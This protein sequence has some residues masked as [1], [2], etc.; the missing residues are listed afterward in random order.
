MKKGKKDSYEKYVKLDN[1][2]T[3]SAA[4]TSL[5]FGATW[6]YIEMRKTFDY[7]KGGNDHL[8]L[9][10]SSVR[11]K[12]NSATFSKYL[13]ELI[14]YGFL[15]IVKHGG[16]MRQSTVHALSDEWRKKSREIVTTEGREAIKL[17][18]AQKPSFRNNINNLRKYTE[19]KR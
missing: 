11:W 7:E 12:M 3:D 1:S 16:L 19:N 18:M 10:Y 6:V 15:R 13:K 17:G 9:P 14:R 5:S 4:W 2:M 8:V